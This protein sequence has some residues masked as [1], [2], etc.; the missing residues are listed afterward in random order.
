MGSNPLRSGETS[1]SSLTRVSVNKL[2][3][4][5]SSGKEAFHIHKV[6]YKSSLIGFYALRR[7]YGF[8]NF[9]DVLLVDF[10]VEEKALNSLQ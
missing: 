4:L 7:S 10:I 8:L 2:A 3:R 5:P 9:F 6:W 1:E